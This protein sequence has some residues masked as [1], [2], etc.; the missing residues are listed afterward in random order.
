MHQAGGVAHRLQE[1]YVKRCNRVIWKREVPADLV[2]VQGMEHV[3]KAEMAALPR[4]LL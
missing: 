1:G 2:H 4:L 3:S